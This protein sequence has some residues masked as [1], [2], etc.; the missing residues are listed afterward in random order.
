MPSLWQPQT[1]SCYHASAATGTSCQ[2]NFFPGSTDLHMHKS[3]LLETPFRARTLE[4]GEG[5]TDLAV[6]PIPTQSRKSLRN[7]IQL[8]RKEAQSAQQKSEEQGE[9]FLQILYNSGTY[10]CLVVCISKRIIAFLN[11]ILALY[12]SLLHSHSCVTI[13]TMNWGK[14]LKN[15]RVLLSTI[16]SNLLVKCY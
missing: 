15:L 6:S 9:F 16:M 7:L 14:K 5:G 4:R 10:C 3:I 8:Q 12:P 13:T 2:Q 1:P 11:V